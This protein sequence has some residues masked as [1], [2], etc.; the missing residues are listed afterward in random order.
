MRQKF[1]ISIGLILAICLLVVLIHPRYRQKGAS[2]TEVAVE[3]FDADMHRGPVA[4]C[5]RLALKADY[6]HDVIRR[7][8]DYVATLGSNTGTFLELA[9]VAADADQECER[10]NAVLDLSVVQS[11]ESRLI[12]ELAQESCESDHPADWE[13]WQERYDSLLSWAQYSSVEEA[14]ASLREAALEEGTR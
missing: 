14:L 6:N 12:V 13:R 10:L 8:A 2:F 1:W 11:S 4:Q 5:A 3:I 9:R 7:V